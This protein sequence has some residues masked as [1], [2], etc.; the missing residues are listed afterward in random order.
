MADKG[1][2]D[3]IIEKAAAAE[4]SQQLKQNEQTSK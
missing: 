4:S 3:T 2:L 1:E